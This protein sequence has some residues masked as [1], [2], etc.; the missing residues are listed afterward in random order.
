M[1]SFSTLAPVW[2]F[3]HW[4]PSTFGQS[5]ALVSLAGEL[6]QRAGSADT[7]KVDADLFSQLSKRECAAFLC[8]P[9]VSESEVHAMANP[10]GPSQA[11]TPKPCWN[12]RLFAPRIGFCEGERVGPAFVAWAQQV[13][14]LLPPTLKLT[15]TLLDSDAAWQNDRTK[16]ARA[17]WAMLE[18]LEMIS[19]FTGR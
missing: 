13:D 11:A 6:S 8:S 5:V 3:Q 1:F 16:H 2:S 4:V 14:S 12:I 19:G 7:V 15:K 18:Q 10:K 17:T 9:I